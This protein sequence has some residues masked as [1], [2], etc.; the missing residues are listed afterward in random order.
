MTLNGHESRIWKLPIT[1]VMAVY[2]TPVDQLNAAIESILRQTF[3]EFEFII[4]NDKSNDISTA[5]LT[6]W[7]SIDK[8]IKIL[9]NPFN[10]GLTKSL[11][12]GIRAS[13]GK[14]IVRQDSDDISEI[15][16]LEL[17]FNFME[18]HPEVHAV[19]CGINIIDHKGSNLGAVTIYFDA[20][21]IFK[22]NNLVHGTMFIRRYVFENLKGYDERLKLS[23][24]YGLYL[25]MI[26]R[27]NMKIHVLSDC[28]YNLRQHQNSLS[29]KK[30][31]KQ[32]YFATAAKHI[33]MGL[34][35]HNKSTLLLLFHTAFDLVFVHYFFITIQRSR[36]M[37][38]IKKS[39]FIKFL[40]H[41]KFK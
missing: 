31:L 17:Q 8:R 36:F 41:T 5:L 12:H 16:R 29:S 7:A 25:I 27:F 23:Q 28:L 6:H 30:K 15:R 34:E 33:S 9:S 37:C 20:K 39:D 35:F 14:Y 22:K 38:L 11:N 26:R 32:L 21:K 40:Q 19:G 2:N 1:V 10:M 4:I 13:R 24:D 18:S 3:Q